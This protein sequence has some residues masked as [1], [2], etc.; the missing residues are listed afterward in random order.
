MFLTSSICTADT[1]ETLVMPGE[2][3]EGH[4]K[5]EN[6]CS[7][8][9]ELFSKR[10]QDKLCLQCH[11]KINRDVKIRKGFH[12]KN[13]DVKNTRC[14]SCHTDHKGR[15][16]DIIKLDEMLFSH[17]KTDYKL[18]GKHQ[19]V[20]CNSCHLENKKHRDASSDCLSCHKKDNPHKNQI[21]LKRIFNSCQNCHN[22]KGWDDIHFDHGK[23]DYKLTGKHKTALCQSCHIN[24][25]YSKTPD[26]CI[27]CHKHNDVHQGKN[28]KNC[29]KCHTTAK[30]GK[31]SFDHNRDTSFVLKGKHIKT[32]CKSCHNNVKIKRDVKNKKKKARNCYSCHLYDDKHNGVF[33]K[34]CAEC[35]IE[36][37]WTDS[38]FNHN[39]DTEFRLKGKH[40]KISCQSC[41]KS[42]DK[43][44][45]KN[46]VSCH[47]PD[48]VHKGSLGN[49]CDSC[50]IE[51]N[52]NTK[53]SFDHDL[54]KFPLIGIHKG[55]SCEECHNSAEFEK[56]TQSCV[57]CHKTSDVHKGRL[58]KNCELCH[59]PNDW[60]VWIFDHNRQSKFKLKNA[61]SKLHCNSCHTEQVNRI[62]GNV[63]SCRNCHANDDVHD[64]Q[65]GNQCDKCHSDKNFKD[66]NM[67]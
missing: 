62:T 38:K 15:G 26:K 25:N 10:G 5:Y 37:K 64:G 39:Q 18:K 8:C 35:H 6:K 34:K 27:S 47:K 55:T 54:T 12:G 61:H 23:T 59:T 57:S 9:H 60:G 20:K 40:V 48:D 2:V 45:K 22:E 67:K 16:A 11:K 56:S 30:W 17:D 36:K 65:F 44:L 32:P 51:K 21:K 53:V 14:K 58:G 49:K 4:K 13:G 7:S 66:I 63:R 52:W 46:C 24:E 29:Q 31:I 1:F 43:N 41:H 42:K 28:G 33:G 3:I 50:H 19:T